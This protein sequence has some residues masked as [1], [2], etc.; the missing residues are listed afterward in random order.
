LREQRLEDL[1]SFVES[2]VRGQMAAM[3]PDA[4]LA[5]VADLLAEAPRLERRIRQVSRVLSKAR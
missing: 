4:M 1:A 2:I 3:G 5:M